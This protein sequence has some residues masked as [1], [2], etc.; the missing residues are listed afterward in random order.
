VQIGF[1]FKY[2]HNNRMRVSVVYKKQECDWRIHA[3]LDAKKESIQIKAFKPS[4]Q[5]WNQYENAK[6]DVE[7]IATKYM[8]SFKDDP[9]WTHM[10]YN[11]W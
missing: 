2:K 9:T 7:Y 11:I 3:S 6:V 5:C 8:S 1:D 10:H 4:H